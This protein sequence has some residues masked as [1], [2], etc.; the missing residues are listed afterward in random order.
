MNLYYCQPILA[1]SDAIV[2]KRNSILTWCS[3]N[4]RQLSCWWNWITILLSCGLFDLGTLMLCPRTRLQIMVLLVILAIC[5]PTLRI[6]QHSRLQLT[7]LYQIPLLVWNISL[8]SEL[9]VALKSSSHV[10]QSN[11]T[12]LYPFWHMSICPLPAQ[13]NFSPD[14]AYIHQCNVHNCYSQHYLHVLSGLHQTFLSW[15]PD[16]DF[17]SQTSQPSSFQNYTWSCNHLNLNLV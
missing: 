11:R 8:W 16:I 6:V 4:C 15:G 17:M 5:I 12:L 9:L 7:S 14:V 1:M 13:G 10:C 2:W 3:Q